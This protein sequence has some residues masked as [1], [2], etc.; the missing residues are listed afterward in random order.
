V[1]SFGRAVERINVLKPDFVLICGDLVQNANEKSFADFKRIKDSFTVPCHCAAGNHDVGNK[2]TVESLEKY[3]ETIGPDYYAFPHKDFTFVVANTQLWKA[4]LAGESE[5]HDAWFRQKLEQAKAESRPVIVVTHYPFFT[6]S[7]DEEE[8]YY[9]LPPGKRKELLALCEK[10]EVVA[11]LS[12]HTHKF[13]ENEYH[14]IKLVTGETT[15]MNV[16]K[17]PL[18]FRLWTAGPDGKLEHRFIGLEE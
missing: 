13:S 7:A 5:K 17:R 3:R 2:P 12:G 11:V 1:K 18:G 9:N 6:K 10:N 4:P 16:D 15:S 8:H 14:G